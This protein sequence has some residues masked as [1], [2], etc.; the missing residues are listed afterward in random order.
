MLQFCQNSPADS[1][2][3]HICL[4]SVRKSSELDIVVVQKYIATVKYGLNIPGEVW[5]G[6]NQYI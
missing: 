3:G 1:E 5:L 2:V 4:Q 6:R